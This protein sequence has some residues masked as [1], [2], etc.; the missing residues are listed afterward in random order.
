MRLRWLA[1]LVLAL[2]LIAPGAAR[3]CMP[4]PPPPQMEG[5][6]DEAYQLRLEEVRAAQAAED[7]AFRARMQREAWENSQ[8]VL[9]ARIER[10]GA[11]VP[12]GDHGETP[13]PTLRPVRW[14]KGSG[15]ARPF[16]VRYTE[17]TSCAPV[18]G[19]DAVRGAVGEE[20]VVFV[21][22]GRPGVRSIIG[23][24]AVNAI[25]DD[26]LRARVAAE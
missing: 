1:A 19:G 9:I 15:P 13:R 24:V 20:F 23:S 18:G 11:V 21:R 2:A 10:A 25:A 22:N 14:L 5:E 12:L 16:H 4:M 17:F 26:Q 3:A 8:S 6:T 7:F